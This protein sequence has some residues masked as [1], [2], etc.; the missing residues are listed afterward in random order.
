QA[1]QTAE[2]DLRAAEGDVRQARKQE[3]AAQ[4]AQEG[5][6]SAL[7]AARVSLRALEGT[8][9]APGG[10]GRI[11]LYSPFDG[12]I[13]RRDVTTG[14]AV[15]GSSDLFTVQNLDN[16]AVEANVPEASVARIRIGTPVTVTVAAYPK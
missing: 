7:G 2:A 8:G 15:E 9:H 5:T 6:R 16:V 13:A 3:Q 14:Q 12:V 1:V 11:A 10:A 4:T